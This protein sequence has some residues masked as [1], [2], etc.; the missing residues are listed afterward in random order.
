MIKAFP[1]KRSDVWMVDFNPTLGSETGKIRPAVVIGTD[2]AN[3]YPAVIV[4]S[5]SLGRLPVKLV[6]PI[7]AWDV[8][9]EDSIWHVQINPSVQNGLTKV[10]S[11]DTLQMRCASTDRFLKKVGI[12]PA[13]IM[14]EIAAAIASVVEY[15]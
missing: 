9:Y 8:R 5:D 1:P 2:S 6:V 11:A 15:N 4:G 13:N 14:E 7:T 10:S 3:V 12:L